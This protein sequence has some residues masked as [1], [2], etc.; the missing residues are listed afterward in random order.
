MKLEENQITFDTQYWWVTGIER[1]S[2]KGPIVDERWTT[3]AE[4]RKSFN[5]HKK[6]M[7]KASIKVIC[8][9]PDNLITD[10]YTLD[11]LWLDFINNKIKE[12]DK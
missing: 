7:L 5:K 3:Y 6:K 8:D 4:A 1:K 2:N 11:M 12:L 10:K 9:T